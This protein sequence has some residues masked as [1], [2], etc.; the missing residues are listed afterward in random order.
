M[1]KRQVIWIGYSII[2]FA[3]IIAAILI[4]SSDRHADPPGTE[5]VRNISIVVSD[6]PVINK[7]GDTIHL[8]YF[9]KTPPYEDNDLKL[10]KIELIEKESGRVIY[11]FGGEKVDLLN[12]ISDEVNHSVLHELSY[13][14]PADTMPSLYTHRLSFISDGRAILPFSISEGDISIP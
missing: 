7:A 13:A 1:Q 2:I 9:L 4:I 6:N 11:T 10:M 14:I 12:Q 8:S 3:M 5:D